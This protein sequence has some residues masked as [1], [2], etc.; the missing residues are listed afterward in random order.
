MSASKGIGSHVE[1]S[2]RNYSDSS[3]VASVPLVS[4]ATQYV[5]R[6]AGT[7]NTSRGSVN[8]EECS[9]C[10]TSVSQADCMAAINRQF[11]AHGFS[12]EARKLFAAS[13]RAGTKKTIGCGKRFWLNTN[14]YQSQKYSLQQCIIC[15]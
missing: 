12:K 13:W 10:R 8:S 1:V 7:E 3:H 6:E 9:T 4:T 5:D 15:R 2:V 11:K 14:Y